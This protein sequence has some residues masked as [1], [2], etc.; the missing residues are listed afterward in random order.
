MNISKK[1]LL[2]S[3]AGL[4]C[5]NVKPSQPLVANSFAT[6]VGSLG[7]SI[8]K[9]PGQAAFYA[10]LFTALTHFYAREPDNAKSRCDWERLAN[11]FRGCLDEKNNTI[12][13]T[14]LGYN[15]ERKEKKELSSITVGI[16]NEHGDILPLTKIDIVKIERSDL[17][18]ACEKLLLAETETPAYAN[19][20]P[21]AKAEYWIKP[22]LTCKIKIFAVTSTAEGSPVSFKVVDP[23]F[24]D[25]SKKEVTTTQDL[26]NLQTQQTVSAKAIANEIWGVII[27][28]VVGHKYKEGSPRVNLETRKIESGPAVAPKGIF[29]YIHGY[30]KPALAATTVLSTIYAAQNPGTIAA[31]A[32]A[33]VEKDPRATLVAPAVYLGCKYLPDVAHIMPRT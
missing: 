33:L 25:M 6:T 12:T 14:I 19:I 30:W 1:I 23:Q 4:V 20:N 28:G 15:I 24:V 32:K 2:F 7:T 18:K 27:D 10:L 22:E 31:L 8:S 13:C 16:R 17:Q 26:A 21:S 11:S 9:H 5:W 29:G 3:L